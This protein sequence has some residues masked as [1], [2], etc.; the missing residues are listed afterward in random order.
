MFLA[1]LGLDL[2]YVQFHKRLP[3]TTSHLYTTSKQLGC[4]SV[5]RRSKGQLLRAHFRARS[6]W[7]P[8]WAGHSR[9]KWRMVSGTPHPSQFPEACLPQRRSWWL[10]QLWPTRRRMMATS[11]LRLGST[12]FRST[13]T[14]GSRA[15]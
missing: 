6:S 5:A 14:V 10:R 15:L 11:F 1:V 4:Q 3:E 2:G 9:R 8:T 12:K 7:R 13:V